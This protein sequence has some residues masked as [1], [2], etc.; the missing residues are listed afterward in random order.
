[1]RF[2]KVHILLCWLAVAV[3]VLPGHC[4]TQLLLTAGRK[5]QPPSLC[6][7]RCDAIRRNRWMV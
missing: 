7:L 1:M 6:T 4:S 2:P 5:M 3:N